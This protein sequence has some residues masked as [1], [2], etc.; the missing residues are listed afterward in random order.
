ME[1]N[2]STDT[3]AGQAAANAGQSPTELKNQFLTLLVT[4]LKNQDPTKPVENQEFVAQLAQ[5]TSLEQQAKI[6]E[7]NESLL[8]Q[9]SLSTGAAL[10][11]KNVSGHVSQGSETIN[12]SGAVKSVN[13]ER[14]EVVYMVEGEDGAIHTM[15]PTQIISVTQ[16]TE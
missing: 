13:V 9:S 4:Q 14:G 16:P 15:R 7:T 8:L 11:G 6:T 12:L 10:I 2:S 5:L 3:L 1:I